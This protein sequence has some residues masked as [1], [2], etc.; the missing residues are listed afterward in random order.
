[1]FGSS[2]LFENN[3]AIGSVQS[4]LVQTIDKTMIKHNLA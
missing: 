3:Y 1:M 2:V 4:H